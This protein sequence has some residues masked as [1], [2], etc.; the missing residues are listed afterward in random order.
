MEGANREYKDSVFTMLFKEKENLISLYNALE[1]KNYPLDTEIKINTLDEVF[2]KKQR[3]DLSFLIDNKFMVL[4]EHR[5]TLNENMP[6][7]QFVVLKSKK[8]RDV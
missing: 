3:N 8:R 4:V 7:P 5:S 2:F 6:P 1:D